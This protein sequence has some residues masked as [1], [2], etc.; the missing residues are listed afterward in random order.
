MVEAK[1][2]SNSAAAIKRKKAQRLCEI[3]ATFLPKLMKSCQAG[4]GEA[5]ADA[6]PFCFNRCGTDHSFK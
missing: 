5:N 1:M 4:G 6:L 2:A 3:R